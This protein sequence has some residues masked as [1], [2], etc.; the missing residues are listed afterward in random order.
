MRVY[1]LGGVPGQRG[2]ACQGGVPA[3]G[4]CW[5][6]VPAWGVYLP[7]GDSYLPVLELEFRNCF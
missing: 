2:C 4:T 1:L 7:G 6:V 3:R 5:G